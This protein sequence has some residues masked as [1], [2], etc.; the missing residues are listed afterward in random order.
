MKRDFIITDASRGAAITVK[1][2]P[3]ANRTE[4]VGIDD[5]GTVKIRLMSPPIAGQANEELVGFLAEVLGIDARGIEIVAGHDG[6]K[7]LISL[8]NIDAATVEDIVRNQS[9]Q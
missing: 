3:K 9:S 8:L 5:D 7:K 2:V 1:I 4:L 6:R